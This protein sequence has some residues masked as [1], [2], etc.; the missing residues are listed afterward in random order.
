FVGNVQLQHI[1]APSTPAEH[2]LDAFA[3][4][5]YPFQDQVGLDEAVRHFAVRDVGSVTSPTP[6]HYAD[7]E[8]VGFQQVG[9]RTFHVAVGGSQAQLRAMDYALT[10]AHM[11]FIAGRAPQ[12]NAGAEPEAIIPTQLAQTYGITLGDAIT[13]AAFLNESAALT[14]RVVG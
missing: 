4:Y 12:A 11:R 2:N 14:V 6:L 5:D 13:V 10:A 9:N 1:L 7:S 3:R 8:P